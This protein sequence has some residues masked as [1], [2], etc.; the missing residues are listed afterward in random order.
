VFRDFE[1][2]ANK[3]AT[4]LA[5]H[6]VPFAFAVR[7]FADPGCVVVDASRAGDHETREKAIGWVKNRLYTVLF[8]MRGSTARI[9]SARRANGSEE[10]LY[11]DRSV[12][13]D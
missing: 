8:T 12:S 1:W 2:D 7:I 10:K 5:K 3:A 9:I 4:N 11:D 13:F 6:G